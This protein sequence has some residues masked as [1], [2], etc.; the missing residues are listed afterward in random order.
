MIAGRMKHRLQVLQPISTEG[1]YGDEVTEWKL[2]NTIHAE[3]VKQT[4]NRSEEVG[5][6]YPNYNVEY[7]IN[8]A[9]KIE[10]NWR[11]QQLGGYLYTV[12]TVI[13]NIDKGMKTLV[14]ERVN[15]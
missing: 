2:V 10:E 3:L 14:C 12:A 4:G 11:V 8:A 5:E 15:E 13:P 7:N 9:H 6:H 1:G